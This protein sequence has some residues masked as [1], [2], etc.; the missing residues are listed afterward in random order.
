MDEIAS[1]DIE[2]KAKNIK[3]LEEAVEVV[4]KMEKIIR[5]CIQYN[6]VYNVYNVVYNGQ[7]INKEKY[8]KNSKRA[9][10]S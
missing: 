5:S 3:S 4:N 8:L 2:N 1:Q 7:P 9:T 10:N 6:V